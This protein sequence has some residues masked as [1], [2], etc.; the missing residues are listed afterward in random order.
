MPS[1]AAGR[2]VVKLVTVGGQPRIQGVCVV[3]DG[4]TLAPVAL[5]DAIALTNLRTAAVSALALDRL[6][7]PDAERLL[8]FGRGPQA[9]AHIEAIRRI[10]PIGRVDQVGRDRDGLDVDSLVAAADI[11]CCCTTARVPL[12][13]GHRVAAHAAVVAIGSHEPDARELDEALVGRS[14]VVVEST[15]LGAAGGRRR[16]PGD[17]HG[18]ARRR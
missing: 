11:I 5:V 13:D 8:V 3:F 4:E 6:A 10:R 17:R 14:T 12:F 16:R 15:S 9:E 2:A 7:A 1:A 18:R